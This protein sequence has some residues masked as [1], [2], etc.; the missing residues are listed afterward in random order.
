MPRNRTPVCRISLVVP[1]SNNYEPRDDHCGSGH[2]PRMRS[3]GSLVRDAGFSFATGPGEQRLGGRIQPSSIRTST[4]SDYGRKPRIG[5]APRDASIKHPQGRR[6]GDRAAQ[7]AGQFPSHSETNRHVVHVQEQFI[8]SPGAPISDIERPDHLK[9]WFP[10][11]HGRQRLERSGQRHRD[12]QEDP[13]SL[14]PG[15]HAAP[16]MAENPSAPGRYLHGVAPSSSTSPRR[17]SWRW[18]HRPILS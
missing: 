7:P 2:Q 9:P 6:R 8:G 17:D 12:R 5:L 11:Q 14:L 15:P 18:T 13:R 3:V 1:G 4:G 16:R 10:A